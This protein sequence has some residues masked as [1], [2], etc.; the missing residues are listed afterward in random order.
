MS[1]GGGTTA[2]F[3]PTAGAATFSDDGW[4]DEYDEDAYGTTPTG[5]PNTGRTPT[6]DSPTDDDARND[7]YFDD[8]NGSSEDGTT[9]TNAATSSDDDKKDWHFN[10]D[11]TLTGASSSDDEKKDWHFDD[12]DGMSYN[13]KTVT[14]APTPNWV[15]STPT[16]NTASNEEDWSDDDDQND[17]DTDVHDGGNPGAY[18]NDN[19]DSFTIDQ[20]KCST[21]YRTPREQSNADLD[22]YDHARSE[23]FGV[24][25]DDKKHTS[26]SQTAAKFAY[27]LAEAEVVEGE[28]AK[29]ET[30]W[31]WLKPARKAVGVRHVTLPFDAVDED[32]RSRTSRGDEFVLTFEGWSEPTS[33][34]GSD[35]VVVKTSV[36]ARDRGYGVYYAT[37]VIP[38]VPFQNLYMT[39]MHY[40]TCYQ[41]FYPG[42][43]PESN[44]Y[45]RLESGPIDVEPHSNFNRLVL[46]RDE[47]D[48]SWWNDDTITLTPTDRS[49]KTVPKCDASQ[50]GIDQFTEGIWAERATVSNGDSDYPRLPKMTGG[51]IC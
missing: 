43:L 51:A 20:R 23:G 36:V 46:G 19:V 21:S 12:D 27:Y 42:Y 9:S 15:R 22:L 34:L 30:G 6:A 7:W 25:G 4:G 17:L 16:T 35:L 26:L 3:V 18:W 32:G 49:W 47:E 44:K 28:D 29:F 50:L 39:L 13:E 45:I 41:G 11:G 37:L 48:W 24:C 1:D 8:G 2:T 38:D 40:Y 5:A 14:D 33:D 31:M 10:E